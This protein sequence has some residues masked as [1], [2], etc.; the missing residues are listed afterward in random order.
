[1]RFL[2]KFFFDFNMVGY[3]IF[4]KKLFDSNVVN[5]VNVAFG[6]NV[7]NVVFK[8]LIDLINAVYKKNF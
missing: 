6:S 2:K 3:M 1:M 5:L 7:I 4:K 8:F